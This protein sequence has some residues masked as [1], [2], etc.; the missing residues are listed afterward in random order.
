MSRPA[1]DL[2]LIVATSPGREVQ[3]GHCLNAL[4]RQ[5]YT[6]FELIVADDGSSGGQAVAEAYAQD[7]SL[8][9]LW[10]PNDGSPARSRNAGAAAARP[11]LLVFID[12]DVLLNPQA[13]TAYA[14]RLAAHPAWL[15]Y[16]YVGI[17]GEAP[18]V[19]VPGVA[20][21]WRDPRFGWNGHQLVPADKLYHSAYEC[22]FGGNF[23][24]HSRSFARLGGFDTRFQG[25]GGEDLEFAERAVTQGLEAHF[26]LDAW[27]EHQLHAR[28]DDFHSRPAEARG[29]GYAFRPHPAVPYPVQVMASPAARHEFETLIKTHYLV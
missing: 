4:K 26:L 7:L 25:W 24:L 21:N 8:R 27:G 16:G 18:S 19:L 23:G 11:G 2:S 17:E 14:G 6:A 12:S 22:G 1:I 10:R 29:H 5:T 3:L 15:L 13:L 20:V 9:Y 28:S